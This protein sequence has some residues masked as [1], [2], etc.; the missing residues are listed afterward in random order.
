[1][2]EELPCVLIVDDVEANLV[3]LEALLSN[4][5]CEL[6]RARSGN[7]GLKE[8]LKREFAVMVL[9]VQMPGMDGFE[10]ARI[11]RSNSATREIPVIFLTAMNQTEDN[12]LQ[13]YGS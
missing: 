2:S 5:G 12:L 8:L 3:A 10:M 1:M 6:V 7:D 11:A 9:D 4:L 13:G